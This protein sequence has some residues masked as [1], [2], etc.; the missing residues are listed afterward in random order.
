MAS[1]DL[2]NGA[3]KTMGPN[4]AL[5][6][7]YQKTTELATGA[8][9]GRGRY[10]DPSDRI[11][12]RYNLFGGRMTCAS[13]I[14][15]N[16]D[17][18]GLAAIRLS[19]NTLLSFSETLLSVLSRVY[20]LDLPPLFG[21]YRQKAPSNRKVEDIIAFT[22]E[23]IPLIN[24]YVDF[25]NIMTYSLINCRDNVTN[26]YTG[27]TLSLEAFRT[28]PEAN[29]LTQPIGYLSQAGAFSW[30]NK[31]PEELAQS[32]SKALSQGKYD[33][34][35][36]TQMKTYGRHLIPPRLRIR[37]SPSANGGLRKP[38]RETGHADRAFMERIEL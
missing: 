32:F 37:P 18:R 29:C 21:S 1:P 25:F 15:M 24:K 38:M 9:H 5:Y 4:A 22:E 13:Y 11:R 19:Y 3:G 7:G 20:S 8:S 36:G 2:C 31:V 10:G 6:V 34:E 28:N 23:T 27:V 35:S 17:K 12:N 30:H 26:H 33:S 16:P 14:S